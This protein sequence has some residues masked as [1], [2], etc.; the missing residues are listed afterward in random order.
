[1]HNPPKIKYSGLTIL[2][3]HPSRFDTRGELIS[4]YA[5][6][7]VDNTILPLSRYS[8]DIRDCSVSAPLLPST[9]VVLLL[10]AESLALVRPDLFQ[11][12]RKPQDVLNE[13]R[14][15]PFLLNEIIYL[16]SYAPQDTFDRRD[17]SSNEDDESESEGGQDSNAEKGHQKTRRKNWK[18]WLYNDLRKCV[19]ILQHGFRQ[20]NPVKHFIFTTSQEICHELGSVKNKHLVFDIE[21]DK[22][23]NLTCFGFRFMDYSLAHDCS[24]IYVVPFKRFNSTLA[25]DSLEICR[26]LRNLAIAFRDN[27]VVGHNLSFDLFVMAYKYRIP[28]PKK[29]FDSM[30]GFHRCTPGYEVVDTLKGKI[31]IRDLVGKSDFWIWS[32][33]DGKPYPTKATNVRKVGNEPIVRVHYWRRKFPGTE[34]CHIDCTPDHK[35]RLLNGEWKEAKDLQPQDSLTRVNIF[36]PKSNYTYINIEG[37][38][39]KL[40]RYVYKA[41]KNK[42]L[43]DGKIVHH[44][45]EN[46]ENNEPE[47]LEEVW[48]DKHNRIHH[49]GNSYR[50]GMKAWNNGHFHNLT[51]VNPEEIKSLYDSGMSQIDISIKYRVNSSCV[52][53]FMKFHNIKVRTFKEA[54]RLR[55]QNDKNCKVIKVEIL[56]KSEDVYC[57]EVEETKC[58]SSDGIIIHNCY[59]EVEKSLGHVIS[60]FPELHLPFHKNDGIF[61]PRNTSQE[62]QLWNYNAQD[63]FTTSLIYPLLIKL[64]ERNLAGPSIEQANRS[65]RPYLTMSYKGINCNIETFLSKF[66]EF[67]RYRKQVGRILNLLTGRTLNPRSSQ[68]V[69]KYL[70]TDLALECPNEDEPT[71]EKTLL[72]LL[73]KHNLPSVKCIIAY[74]GAGKLASTLKFRLWSNGHDSCEYNRFTSSLN[75]AGTETFRLGSRALLKFKPDKGFGSNAQNWHKKLRD[76]QIPDLGKIFVK[77]DQAGA[78]ALIVAYLCRHGRF[79]ELF[80]NGV[81]PHVFVGLHLFKEVWKGHIDSSVVEAACSSRISDLK[82]ISGWKELDGIIKA[83]DNW[84]SDKRYYFIAKQVCHS[85]NYDIKPPTFQMNTLLK[86]EGT[87]VLSHAMAKKFLDFYRVELF[88]E[89][90]EWH[91]EIQEI[92][93]S[94]RTLFNLF[95]FPRKFHGPLDET[96]FKAAYAFIPQSTVASITNIAVTELQESIELFSMQGFDLLNNEHDSILSQCLIGHEVEVGRLISKHINKEMTHKGTKFSMKSECQAGYNGAPKSMKNVGGLEELKL[97]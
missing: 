2:L 50:K 66:T 24:P 49:T 10:G 96:L 21:T 33:K 56:N 78:E 94:S 5:G 65:I 70:Y 27:T 77:V 60:F 13:Q 74:R 76:I 22:Q 69:S 51:K 68:Q 40:H 20:P 97:N 95:G 72:K 18:F 79:R 43:A 47:N 29:V 3:N 34:V 85:S 12:N 39:E 37:K 15:C 28:F 80:L 48:Q 89:I 30:L 58:Y 67:E 73:I 61:E 38:L 59:P 35:F 92:I 17:F 32:W 88:P 75:I 6:Q 9:R 19:Y 90:P 53:R 36:K 16:P 82:N 4:G 83:S 86:S 14:G 11:D 62:Y 93:K 7:F 71:N 87:V 42:D 84:A 26:I 1:M 81:K 91:M 23:F 25:Y 45:D 46:I 8:I 63:I 31:P 44:I 54:Q 57:L 52:T 64:G 55:R 41:I